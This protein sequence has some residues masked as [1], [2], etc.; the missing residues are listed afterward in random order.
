MPRRTIAGTAELSGV[1]LHTGASTRVSCQPAESDR[2]VFFRRTDLES[3]PEIPA[4]V[5][6]VEATE[7]RTAIGHGDTT[8]HTVEH[9]LAAVAALELDDLAIELDGPEP[10]ILDGSF[11]PYLDLLEGAGV[12]TQAGE[13]ANYRV[14]APFTLAEGDASYIV[15]PAD[16]LRLTATIELRRDIAR[17]IRQVRP[18]RV[19]CQ[20]PDR[21][22]ERI[23]ASHP[24]HLA[25]GEATLCAVY[26][27]ARNEFAHPELAEEGLAPHTVEEVW[28]IAARQA[29][30][31]ID[32]TDTVDRKVK[33][34]LCHVSQITE[35]DAL[36]ARIRG[37]GVAVAAT[38]GLPEG[39]LAEGFQIVRT[40]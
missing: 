34:L 31:H 35:P 9:L 10:P 13:P 25:A 21:M 36:E 15:S 33:A 23:F 30:H 22:Y 28:L 1:G 20:S 8:I 18:R 3:R 17:V 40:G 14:S 16:G 29:D 27:D 2:G 39:R 6:E 4:R 38:G 26:P 37:W 32:V 11:G 24:D 19:V 12:C 7:R 5:S